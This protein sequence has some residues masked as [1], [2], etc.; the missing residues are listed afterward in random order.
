MSVS[1][2]TVRL[3]AVA[4]ALGSAGK[5][6]ADDG[7]TARFLE[8]EKRVDQSTSHGA[9][10]QQ[11][12]QLTTSVPPLLHAVAGV[13]LD[14]RAREFADRTVRLDLLLR[15]R[16]GTLVAETCTATAVAEAVLLTAFHCV[17]GRPARA[18]VVRARAVAHYNA[19]GRLDAVSV[20]EVDPRP[21]VDDERRDVS[22]V[23]LLQPLQGLPR[24]LPLRV[25]EPVPGETLL[26][27]S[28]PVG[29]AKH[30]SSGNCVAAAAQALVAN[31]FRHHCATL[32]GSS[33]G[34]VVAASDLAL[35]GVHSSG[36]STVGV[37]H[38]LHDHAGGNLLARAGVAASRV[39]PPE[40][41][42]RSGWTLGPDA[43]SR[44]FAQAARRGMGA[45]WLRSVAPDG[46]TAREFDGR[47][48][49]A[50]LAVDHSDAGALA[51]LRASGAE[52]SGDRGARLLERA[53]DRANADGRGGALDAIRELLRAGA[54]P[55]RDANGQHLFCPPGATLAV[56]GV[57]G[58]HGYAQSMC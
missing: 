7:A 50:E 10:L 46:G 49:F 5:V 4:L 25:R 21:L 48:R 57:F 36:T 19:P 1:R 58:E 16:D 53:V 32:P 33:G 12:R 6:I 15:N 18:V 56:V 14:A 52:L 22:L 44:S 26:I 20:A 45:Q 13:P 43:M 34:A 9:V 47:F 42:D 8:L 39:G 41:L 24:A 28:H 51:S 35:V 37:A 17:P 11:L 55:R 3:L 29:Q 2:A 38:S 23:R 27:V 31:Q 30:L 54:R 40:N